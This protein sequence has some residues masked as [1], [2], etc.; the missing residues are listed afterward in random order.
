MANADEWCALDWWNGQ[1]LIARLSGEVRFR[2]S[3]YLCGDSC[4][5]DS[6]R[7]FFAGILLCT[8]VRGGCALETHETPDVKRLTYV[9]PSRARLERRGA[10]RSST[11]APKTM[12]RP[13]RSP[14]PPPPVCRPQVRDS[15]LEVIS[16]LAGMSDNL[17]SRVGAV[18]GCMRTLTRLVISSSTGTRVDAQV[19][20]ERWRF[21][22]KVVRADRAP[23][24]NIV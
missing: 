15:S 11:F 4:R 18:P 23:S 6:N 7:R 8:C 24:Q 14:V 20:F 16:A 10:S 2:K 17:R 13:K 1:L 9:W 5:F 21:L 12:N 19:G 22:T 3:G